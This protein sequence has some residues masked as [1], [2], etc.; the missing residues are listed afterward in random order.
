MALIVQPNRLQGLIWQALLKSQGISA[1][2][3][4]ANAELTEC[5]EQ[6]SS[7]GLT[8]PEIII[9]DVNTPGLNPYEFCRWCRERF[10]K[11]KVFLTRVHTRPL[12]EAECRWAV[13]QGATGFFNG[14]TRETLMSTAVV[15]IK[16]ILSAIGEPF[17]DEQALLT[18]LLN[19][20]RQTGTAKAA[21]AARPPSAQPVASPKAPPP[22]PCWLAAT[23]GN[24]RRP[25]QTTT[26]IGWHR[27]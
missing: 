22:P 1:I 18:V 26:W 12:T 25:N 21:V 24:L 20:R 14:F 11:T 6:I 4:S 17:L 16:Q 15:N 2:L 10:P 3:E 5:L 7:A 8:L 9:V 19:I 27:G 23:A 13:N